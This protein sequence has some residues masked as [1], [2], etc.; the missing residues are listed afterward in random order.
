MR[1]RSQQLTSRG[2]VLALHC[3]ACF[4]ATGCGADGAPLGPPDQ[5]V[6]L[7]DAALTDGATPLLDQGR[8]DA[9]ATPDAGTLDVG[10]ADAGSGDASAPVDLGAGGC[11]SI[12]RTFSAAGAGPGCG[13]LGAS[14][15]VQ[16]RSAGAC[17]VEFTT[18]AVLSGAVT[19]VSDGSF[20]GQ[21]LSLG[22]TPRSCRGTWS[23]AFA[24]YS[25]VCGSG[26][27]VCTITL[28]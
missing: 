22:G 23:A 14:Q 15:V 27:S 24:R 18:A 9:G 7:D 28:N 5:A 16:Q 26:P 21:T 6:G 13:T 20:V 4:A 19:V 3:M 2:V 1:R 8:T 10:R 11:P 17:L 12:A 25:V